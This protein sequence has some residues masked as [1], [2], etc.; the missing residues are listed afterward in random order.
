MS[1]FGQISNQANRQYSNPPECMPTSVGEVDQILKRISDR[2]EVLD[3]KIN[4]TDVRFGMVLVSAQPTKEQTRPAHPMTV[5]GLGTTLAEFAE[6][7]QR[8][9][10]RLDSINQR[11]QL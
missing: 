2:L 5:T 1:N 11:C 6:N 8:A 10:D 3:Q 7:L 9:I 4:T